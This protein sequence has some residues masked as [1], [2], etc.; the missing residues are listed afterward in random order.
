V[1]ALRLTCVLAFV[2]SARA[3]LNEAEAIRNGLPALPGVLALVDN[4]DPDTRL[5]A[6]RVAARIVIDHY[7]RSAPSGMRLVYGPVRITRR[8]VKLQGGLYLA[9]REVTR[10]EFIAFA[11]AT[12][13]ARGRW[14]EG[15]SGLP[16]TW[17]T[18]QDALA[19]ARW[20][21][22]RL[23]TITELSNACTSFGRLPYPWGSEF[24]ARCLNSREGGRGGEVAPGSCPRGRSPAGIDDLLGNV[25]EWTTTI[26]GSSKRHRVFGGSYRDRANGRRAPFGVTRMAVSARSATVGFR[27]AQ[28]LPR[29]PTEPPR[30]PASDP[31]RP[32]RS[33]ER[34]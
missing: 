27:L 29:L 8:G 9:A 13:R 24:D 32:S 1:I 11:K 23:P 33:G 12:H 30:A 15:E 25:S 19:Y 17:A 18:M 3:G 28:S 21:K 4:K 7:V 2:A 26:T 5:R 34:R 6:R 31:Q 22:A 10:A 20:K 14:A 16:V